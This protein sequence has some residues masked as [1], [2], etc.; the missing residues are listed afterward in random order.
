[1][2]W[3]GFPQ[4]D[5]KR[6]REG[7]KDSFGWCVCARVPFDCLSE[8]RTYIDMDT[9]Q[10]WHK[11]PCPFEKALIWSVWHG[12]CTIQY[13]TV[14]Y[15]IYMSISSLPQPHINCG[16]AAFKWRH[17]FAFKLLIVDSFI[18]S[19]CIRSLN[20]NHLELFYD[21]HLSSHHPKSLF[22]VS[23]LQLTEWIISLIRAI[24]YANIHLNDTVIKIS[25]L[26]S[27]QL[28]ERESE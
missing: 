15:S 10:H 24:S 19:T 3:F 1:M 9:K 6:T 5:M 12:D 16:H 26:S 27:V 28:A 8:H 11:C 21:G 2:I 13:N 17:E 25:V 20:Y 4:R 14:Q 23:S 18:L 7:E 22:Y